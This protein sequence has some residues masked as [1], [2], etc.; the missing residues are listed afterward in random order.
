MFGL[1][2]HTIYLIKKDGSRE[3]VCMTDCSTKIEVRLEVRN[4]IQEYYNDK[5]EEFEKAEYV[6]KNNNVL[7]ECSINECMEEL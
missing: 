4:L 6:D 5:V 2:T 3:N 7:Y 1:P